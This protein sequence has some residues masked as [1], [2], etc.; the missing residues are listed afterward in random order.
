MVELAKKSGLVWIEYAGRTHAVWHVWAT[1]AICVVAGGEEQPLPG[2]AQQDEVLITLRSK[3]TRFQLIRIKAGVDVLTTRS[4]AWIE[5][6][7]ALVAARLNLV[8]RASAAERWDAG[9]V[10][11]RLVPTSIDA[12]PGSLGSSA[13][14]AQPQPT[15]AT[16]VSSRPYVLHRRQQSRPRLSGDP[17]PEPDGPRPA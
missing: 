15:P 7:K 17:V 1:E 8:E 11:V 2:V 13:Q 3:A 14:R 9:S 16:T 6:T 4:P 12:A 5:V 10:V